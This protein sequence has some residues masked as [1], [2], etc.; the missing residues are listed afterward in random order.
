M[1]IHVCLVS[2]Q[3]LANLIPAL[4]ERPDLVIL[5]ASAA[6]KHRGLDQRLQDHLQTEGI[7]SQIVEDA[8]DSGLNEIRLYAEKL[9]EVLSEAYP[10]AAVTLNATGGKKLMALGFVPIFDAQ[11]SRIIYTDTEHRRIELVGR[12]TQTALPMPHVLDIPGYLAAQGIRYSHAD[13]DDQNR[14]AGIEV[15]QT[16][17]RF[18]GEHVVGLQ[19]GIKIFNGIVARA[20]EKDPASQ[21]DRLAHPDFSLTNGAWGDF[22]KLLTRCEQ[23]ALIEWNPDKKAGRFADLEAARYLGGIWLE[24]YAWL[25]ARDCKPFDVRMGVHR[26]GDNNEEL[27]EFDLLAV[28]GNQLLYVECK[29]ANYQRQIGQA[30][31]TAYKIDSLSRL[32]RG[33][34][35]ETWLLSAIEPPPELQERA[36]SLRI[37]ILG[38]NDLPQLRH[39]VAVWMNK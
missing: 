26:V 1:K 21:Q 32:A 10:H 6:M 24:E 12:E 29:T 19:A 23:L 37:R 8:P 3:I 11:K 30:N 22:A 2:D 31:Q 5:V 34:F 38:P 27:N 7:A 35:G 18:M 20:I 39:H 16:L 13:S 15:R 28:H 4:M 17:T 9:I 14:L 25:C 33:L 36:S